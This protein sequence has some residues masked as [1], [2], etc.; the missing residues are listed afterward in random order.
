MQNPNM[1]Q[2]G[3]FL[4]FFQSLYHTPSSSYDAKKDG[5]E[6][7]KNKAPSDDK[8]Q[9]GTNQGSKIISG[10]DVYAVL[11][12]WAELDEY[13]RLMRAT[14]G[15]EKTKD[16]IIDKEIL[17]LKREKMEN[18]EGWKKRTHDLE[19]QQ[20]LQ[21]FQVLS[22]QKLAEKV[23]LTPDTTHSNLLSLPSKSTIYT[24]ETSDEN[25]N[26]PELLIAPT[27]FS[28]REFLRLSLMVC[29]LSPS[30]IEKA[31]DSP[32]CGNPSLIPRLQNSSN[33]T[34]SK[35]TSSAANMLLA[36][37]SEILRS[38]IV[39]LWIRAQRNGGALRHLIQLFSIDKKEIEEDGEDME[40]DIHE[41]DDQYQKKNTRKKVQYVAKFVGNTTK[42]RTKVL[43]DTSTL[44]SLVNF[45]IAKQVLSNEY[46][47]SEFIHNADSNDVN[48]PFNDY[49][50]KRKHDIDDKDH[51]N[52]SQKKKKALFMTP[53]SPSPPETIDKVSE[54]SDQLARRSL[55]LRWFVRRNRNALT[56]LFSSQMHKDIE[57]DEIDTEGNVQKKACWDHIQ[58]QIKKYTR[59]M[60]TTDRTFAR[61]DRRIFTKYE[62]QEEFCKAVK[63]LLKGL[64]ENAPDTEF[65]NQVQRA[66]QDFNIFEQNFFNPTKKDPSM[67][68]NPI[69]DSITDAGSVIPELPPPWID[70]CRSCKKTIN[71]HDEKTLCRCCG[72][73]FHKKCA[74]IDSPWD[75]R[76]EIFNAGK[77]D[78][79]QYEWGTKIK[80][81]IH[82]KGKNVGPISWGLSFE[83][84][85]EFSAEIA[86]YFAGN[87]SNNPKEGT[88]TI[89]HNMKH[90]GLVV[91][92]VSKSEEE[93]GLQIGDLIIRM[94]D[95]D[96]KEE[97]EL[98][99]MIDRDELFF[100]DAYNRFQVIA[101][102]PSEPFVAL[103]NRNCKI[104][105]C[106]D[107]EKIL[108]KIEKKKDI[109]PKEMTK[110]KIIFEAKTC[111][112][113]IRRLG[114]ESSSLHFHDEHWNDSSFGQVPF[115]SLRRIDHMM[116]SIIKRNEGEPN[117]KHLMP[118]LDPFLEPLINNKN[119]MDV[120]KMP[121]RVSW[122]PDGVE[123]RPCELLCLGM[124]MILR[125][126][127]MSSDPLKK[128]R[129]D[130]ARRFI[131]LLSSWCFHARSAD[132]DVVRPMTS[133]VPWVYKACQV[134]GVKK[135]CKSVQELR[136]GKVCATSLCDEPFCESYLKSLDQHPIKDRNFTSAKSKD[137]EKR[138]PPF[139][140]WLSLVGTV[141][142]VIPGDPIHFKICRT[143]KFSIEH[144]DR[145]IEVLILSY[146]PNQDG[147]S[148]CVI[149]I[150]SNTQLYNILEYCKVHGIPSP[151]KSK[152]M[153]SSQNEGVKR[154]QIG[155]DSFYSD[156]VYFSCS[157]IEYCINETLQIR[158]ALD[159]EI[160]RL[161]SY[162]PNEDPDRKHFTSNILNHEGFNERVKISDHGNL[163]PNI[164][165]LI[166][167]S[168]FD[169]FDHESLHQQVFFDVIEKDDLFKDQFQLHKYNGKS[170]SY[171]L[172]AQTH[173]LEYVALINALVH[174]SDFIRKF[175]TEIH[176]S[177]KKLGCNFPDNFAA[178]IQYPEYDTD[179]G[180]FFTP[181]KKE[182]M[183]GCLHHEE[184]II[185]NYGNDLNNYRVCYV[186]F[187]S[188][189]MVPHLPTSDSNK[190]FSKSNSNF[191]RLMIILNRSPKTQLTVNSDEDSDWNPEESADK[192]L[193]KINTTNKKP[194][195]TLYKGK[196]WGLELLKWSNDKKRLRVG[197]IVPNS[198]AHTST[199]FPHDIVISINGKN[200]QS[201]GPD[202]AIARALLWTNRIENPKEQSAYDLSTNPGLF[203]SSILP[204]PAE[205]PVILEIMR[206]IQS[207]N[208]LQGSISQLDQSPPVTYP[209]S[210]RVIGMEGKTYSP[211]NIP[212][213]PLPR[214]ENRH[215]VKQGVS[216]QP[217]YLKYSPNVD[218]KKDF[219]TRETDQ[220]KYHSHSN[221]SSTS[222]AQMQAPPQHMQTQIQAQSNRIQARP[223][224]MQT[225]MQAPPQH[226]QAKMQAQPNQ[227]QARPQ[228]MR[229]QI[230]AQPNQVQA[231]PQHMQPQ[232][233][234]QPNQIQARPQ[235][236]RS[237]IQAQPNQIQARPQHMQAQ[238]NRIQLST[239]YNGAQM[240]AQPDHVQAP[241]NYLS[242]QPNHIKTRNREVH[243]NTNMNTRPIF[244]FE[245][246]YASGFP[247]SM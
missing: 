197:R 20:F 2:I 39:A 246:L 224:H 85:E 129:E 48:D 124:Q 16:Q 170:E 31:S 201:I 102:R 95:C 189:A 46:Q 7:N 206:R 188:D 130:L 9:R 196:G 28:W 94:I 86:L 82:R 172:I 155:L 99:S 122:A 195:S 228:H 123:Q 83:P 182:A 40:N 142:L 169:D 140:D 131:P 203:L 161:V 6:N 174:E 96:S 93:C 198:P 183:N 59:R 89:F 154:I 139:D 88:S 74:S 118:L 53:I 237:Q 65:L 55:I 106:K 26:Q 25:E 215:L 149:P 116:T 11:K 51:G 143:L 191:E 147:G 226:M 14:D 181:Y 61:I 239:H 176:E 120:Q 152:M 3:Q 76:N 100:V 119:V 79:N 179:V 210:T 193:K 164:V 144:M 243:S 107:C 29:A 58:N 57:I 165:S 97:Y 234:A 49:K 177:R 207:K 132:N 43:N 166:S 244:T 202:F 247:R 63:L 160:Y 136:E 54:K 27:L 205:G 175:V 232:I 216:N 127:G 5:D 37:K 13:F 114:M 108:K 231:R 187:P 126:E 68:L 81:I 150:L 62:G 78:L 157:E 117:I 223:Q 30:N 227:I 159:R 184:K 41:E 156:F 32:L 50:K 21:N 8:S 242:S 222:Q 121:R 44:E 4:T 241:T 36:D 229:S 133:I 10:S 87:W 112:N 219:T 38:D 98:G 64:F 22:T 238:P 128:E 168:L 221:Y 34:K 105:Y 115:V 15:R 167:L 148:F 24:A 186:D 151:S 185:S 92:S 230:Q 101:F 73:T 225:Q 56:N 163:H 77:I 245:L 146:S 70:Q 42:T 66:M 60:G 192:S 47:N 236:M 134:C 67:Y 91:T 69:D 110:E 194:S 190:F 12:D 17:F 214:Q 71:D 125:F 220:Y 178:F 233:Q 208:P 204:V 84:S 104:E 1:M 235:H 240:Q 153:M 75:L 23:L 141:I 72:Y 113:I 45:V 135:Q 111:R 19:L 138:S 35:L 217:N 218:S 180:D 212:M 137:L 199:I 171:D 200:V 109:E 213:L 52:Y 145:L 18:I 33:K 158:V 173:T 103:L 80:K 211:Y 90:S 209:F 162:S